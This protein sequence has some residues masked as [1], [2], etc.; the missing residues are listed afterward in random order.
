MQA[1]PTDTS[2]INSS[3]YAANKF[4]N[5]PPC[6]AIDAVAATQLAQCMQSDEHAS[7]RQP[8]SSALQANSPSHS[9]PGAKNRCNQL[10]Q[11]DNGIPALCSAA[12]LIHPSALERRLALLRTVPVTT[13][14][15]LLQQHASKPSLPITPSQ[16]APAAVQP[17][18]AS[19][20]V[21][22]PRTQHNPTQCKKSLNT[23]LS[24]LL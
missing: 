13:E 10:S 20:H 23:T 5:A 6:G 17:H 22:P 18:D 9:S 16:P 11:L 24:Q 14:N 12:A 3:F 1:S 19:P 4:T 7:S 8:K 21:K 15:M 2:R